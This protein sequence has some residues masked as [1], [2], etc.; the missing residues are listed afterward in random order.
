MTQISHKQIETK[1]LKSSRGNIFFAKDFD[2]YGTP[3]NIRQVLSRLEQEGVLRRIA[4]GIYLKPKIDAVI[5]EV[6]PSL[7]EIAKEIAKRD[8]VQIIPTGVTAL[9]KLG[10]TTQVPLKAVYLTDGSPRQIKIGKRTIKFKRTVP[11]TFAIKNDQLQLIVQAL[12][13][14]GQKNI[15]ED[16]LIKLKPSIEKLDAKVIEKELKFA[17]VWIQ[18]VIKNSSK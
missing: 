8:R 6:I 16:F 9:L 11:K 3:G 18:K 5:G 12:K 15:E 10:L 1:I 4:H 17:P 14:K 13:E 7:E 2:D